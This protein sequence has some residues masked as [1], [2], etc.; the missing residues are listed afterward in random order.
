MTK[1]EGIAFVLAKAIA[2]ANPDHPLERIEILQ[3][4]TTGFA[5]VLLTLEGLTLLQETGMGDQTIE[6]TMGRLL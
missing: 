6:Y 4:L 3:H 1:I 5:Q 2:D